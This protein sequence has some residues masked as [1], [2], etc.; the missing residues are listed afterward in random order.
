MTH[1][2]PWGFTRWHPAPCPP[3][4]L[5]LV[6]KRSQA[7]EAWCGPERHPVLRAGSSGVPVTLAAEVCAQAA[8]RPLWVGALSLLRFSA[9]PVTT[10][11]RWMLARGLGTRTGPV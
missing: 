7:L 4:S 3:S 8:C 9:G 11:T 2:A 6:C 5:A 10:G 1:A